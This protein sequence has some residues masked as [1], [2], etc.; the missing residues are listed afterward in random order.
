MK[1]ENQRI[2]EE[3][4]HMK[5]ICGRLEMLERMGEENEGMMVETDEIWFRGKE[6]LME[7]LNRELEREI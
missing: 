1:E 5:V 2:E 7:E 6:K 4:D 3:I